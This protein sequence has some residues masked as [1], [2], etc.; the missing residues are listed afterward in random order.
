MTSLDSIKD[1]AARRKSR[2]LAVELGASPL[3]SAD[4]DDVDSAEIGFAT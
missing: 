4:A 1:R 2:P 3:S